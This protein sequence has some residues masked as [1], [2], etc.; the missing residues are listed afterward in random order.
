MKSPRKI[1]IAAIPVL[2]GWGIYAVAQ[3]AQPSRPVTDSLQ[4]GPAQAP[5]RRGGPPPSD[6]RAKISVNSNLVVL[7]VTVKDR[8]GN[9]VADLQRDEFRVLED[10]VE[11]KIDVFTAEAFPLSMII[12]LDNDLKEKDAQQVRQSLDAVVGGLSLEDEAFICRFDEF[13][14]PGKGFTTDHDVL[15]T[16]LQRTKL[17]TEPSVAPPGGAVANPPS[18]NGH[19]AIGDQPNIA[20]ATMAIGG[21]PTKALDDAVFGAAQLLRDRDRNRRKVILLISDGANGGKKTNKMTYDSVVKT[22]Q[23]DNI[24]VYS[25]AVASAFLERKLSRLVDYAH[26]SGGEI[27]FA[28]KRET[29]E[30]L[31]ARISEEVRN[32]YTIAYVPRGTDRS[33]EFHN[34]EVRVKREGLSIKTRN[35][36]YSGEVPGGMPQ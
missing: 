3:T 36:Y 5:Q 12:L 26:A 24:E 22:L 2:T 33:A 1:A 8:S 20:Y 14:H 27:Y 7:P 23:H 35:R 13:F 16:E 4:S 11:Q 18:I 28:A 6:A 30:E 19:S 31:Y 32:Q 25:V 29:L 34:V 10:D 9:L 17:D 15:L 21:Q